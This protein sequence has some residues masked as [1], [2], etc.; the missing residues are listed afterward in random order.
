MRKV[1]DKAGKY[2]VRPSV[3]IAAVIACVFAAATLWFPLL[4]YFA[5]LYA[6]LASFFALLLFPV[7]MV[8]DKAGGKS[9]RASLTISAVVAAVLFVADAFVL[10]KQTFVDVLFGMAL[11][12]FLPTTL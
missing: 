12:Y 10:H 9:L 7:G 3:V 2:S 4:P 11:L 6:L 5:L 1:M 8:L